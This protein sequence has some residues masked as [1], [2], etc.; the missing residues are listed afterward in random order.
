M[1]EKYWNKKYIYIQM[2]ALLILVIIGILLHYSFSIQQVATE[3]CFSIL[4]D[5]RDQMSQMVQYELEPFASVFLPNAYR[6]GEQLMVFERGTGDLLIDSWNDGLG[7]IHDLNETGVSGFDW[8]TVQADYL[9]GGEGHGAFRSQHGTEDVYLS[10]AP[11]PHSDWEIIRFSPG[12]VC[13]K[14]A[15]SSKAE[16]ERETTLVGIRI[17]LAE[18]NKLNCMVATTLLESRGA[19]V[20]RAEDG[21]KAL[22]AFRDRP[23][24]SFDVILMDVMMPV[25]NGMEAAKAIRALPR[26]DAKEIPIIVLT[27]NAFMEGEKKC[28]EAGMNA[29]LPKPMDA[30]KLCQLIWQLLHQNTPE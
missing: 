19:T 27:A 16:L 7:S 4:D 11:I 17:L 25:M 8:E 22:T 30:E 12:S 28:L 5:S 29:H 26:P 2:T 18:D 20:F 13:M 9:S 24:G 21:A 23:S 10:Y 1:K 3:Q 15:R 14:H 6:Q